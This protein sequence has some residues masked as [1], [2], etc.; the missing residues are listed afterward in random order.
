MHRAWNIQ[1]VVELIFGGADFPSL[2]GLAQTC[3][4]FQPP[5][6]S[7]LW[8][9][10]KDLIQLLKCL[11]S[12]LWEVET[13]ESAVTAI[14][15]SSRLR[16]LRPIVPSDWS[17]V[18]F[19]GM[20]VK[21]FTQEGPRPAM[22]EIYG[23]MSLTLPTT[24]LFPNIRHLT[25]RAGDEIFPYI[26]LL[27]G[28][29][30]R[31]IT[32][33]MLGSEGLRASLLPSLT[34]FHPKLTHVEFDMFVV[35]APM[36]VEAI[37]TAICSWNHLE[38]LSFATLNLASMLHLARL[39]NLRIL[40]V[41]Q[42]PSDPETMK[43]FRDGVAS[44]A[45][46]PVFAALHEFRTFSEKVPDVLAFFNA[47]DPD[48]LDRIDLT[49]EA[50]TSSEMWTTLT[51]TLAEA[52]KSLTRLSLKEQYTYE[53]DVPDQPHL[54]LS[55]DCLTPLL[56]SSNMTEVTFL[57]AHGIDIDDTTIKQMALAWPLLRKLDLAP[58]CQS[59]HYLPKITLGGL[60]PLA[61]Y[62]QMLSSLTLV[63]NALDADPY[64]TEKPG[65]GIC[66][67]SLVDL[68]VVES[69]IAFP[70]AVA[71]FLS[72][73]FPNIQSISTREEI[74]RNMPD[75]EDNMFNW[76]EVNTLVRVFSAVRAQE[77]LSR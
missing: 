74:L 9:D 7:V 54:M 37:Y 53:H 31:S 32:C 24:P 34:T 61:Q 68:N 1:E 50:P 8:R 23:A 44:N 55:T 75:W 14:I 11:P 35:E 29:N 46:G 69:P 2:A 72:A 49:L 77:S 64:S 21:S 59:V 26:R 3:Q 33:G 22:A 73:V 57:A 18:L 67:K 30:L 15:T 38:K 13:V 27:V 17:R 25:W 58:G 39:P 48:A 62:C 4:A 42:L 60:I 66:N 19:Y 41:G 43:G 28:P 71:A 76:G 20:Y 52:S 5:A 45:S 6:L 16:L 51:T 65:G 10:Q 12:D 47:I 40:H 63:V 70:G 56:S 36:I